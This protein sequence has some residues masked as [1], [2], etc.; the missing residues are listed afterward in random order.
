MSENVLQDYIG[1]SFGTGKF[2]ETT[3]K[4]KLIHSSELGIIRVSDGS[5]F[6]ENLLPTIQDKTV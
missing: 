4:E 3:G 6:S 5:R 2:D 1:F